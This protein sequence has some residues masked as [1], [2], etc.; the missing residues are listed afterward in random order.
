MAI[1]DVAEELRAVA[2]A[3][4]DA[5]GYFAAVYS[6]VTSTIATSIAEGRFADGPRMERF[7]STFAELYTRCLGPR[8]VRARCWQAGFDVAGDRDLIILQHLLIGF[9]AH[10][11]HDLPQA[12]VA[13]ADSTGDL[14]AVKPDFDAIN[15]LLGEMTLGVL[16]DL[17]RVSRWASEVGSFGG[18]RFFNFSLVK[19]RDQAWR[20][21]ERLFPLS[22][23]DRAVEVAELDRLTSVLAYLITR[24]TLPGRLVVSV[25][26]R[27]EERDPRKVTAALLGDR[28]RRRP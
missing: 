25:A 27:L 22:A 2:R 4:D 10:V 7:A 9:N 20:T 12:V 8:P 11:T 5:V 24:P 15:I 21:A 6:R 14:Q 13:V 28:S 1:A 26:R 16:S 23:A 19:A 17:D 18:G 3:S